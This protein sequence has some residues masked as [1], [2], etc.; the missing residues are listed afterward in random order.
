[1]FSTVVLAFFIVFFLFLIKFHIN[2]FKRRKIPF[3]ESNFL[4]GAFSDFILQKKSIYDCV[5]DIYNDPKL[6]NEK[7]FGIYIIHKRAIFLKD[8][9]LIKQILVHDGNYFTDR[10][11]TIDKKYPLHGSVGE[12]LVLIERK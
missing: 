5:V 3:L 8:T 10:M 11:L 12:F 1:M 9:K 4:T 7:F 2:Y 6:K